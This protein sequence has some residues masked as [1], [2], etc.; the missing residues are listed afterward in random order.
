[1]DQHARQVII[2]L[3][4]AEA[5]LREGNRPAASRWFDVAIREMALV[6]NGPDRDL[7]QA[8]FR[9]LADQQEGGSPPTG[10]DRE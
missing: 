9:R 8:E 7:A 4:K 3:W 1:M 2:A 10:H 5:S 6:P